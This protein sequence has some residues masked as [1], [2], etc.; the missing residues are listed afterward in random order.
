VAQV[1][2]EVPAVAALAEIVAACPEDPS[3]C[4]SI[5]AAIGV[6]PDD[7]FAL[8]YRDG[9]ITAPT[10]TPSE[11]LALRGLPLVTRALDPK[12]PTDRQPG[13]TVSAF[14]PTVAVI[15]VAAPAGDKPA[16]VAVY[17]GRLGSGF[18]SNAKKQSQYDVTV[19]VGGTVVATTLNDRDVAP[20]AADGHVRSIAA[21]SAPAGRVVSV[22]ALG[23][24]PTVAYSV[25]TA[26]DDVLPLAVLAVSQPAQVALQAE[27]RAFTEVFVTAVVV[28]LLVALIAWQLGRRLVRPVRQLTVVA[29]Q[30]R[31]GDLSARAGLDGVDEVGRL[32]RAMDAMTASLEQSTTDLRTA[33]QEQ[34]AISARLGAVLDSMTEALVVV[35][36]D[37]SIGQANPAAVEL[38]GVPADDLLG[39]AATEVLVVSDGSGPVGLGPG[40]HGEGVLTRDDGRAV[41]VAYS[42]AALTGPGPRG[43]VV[44]L[45]DTTRDREVERMKTEFLSN[46]SHELR[47]PLTP[48]RGYAEILVSKPG[49]DASKV[50]AFATTIRDESVKMNRVVD[51]LVDVAAIEAGRVHIVPRPVAVKDLLDGRIAEWKER[52]PERAKDLKRRVAAG[53]PPVLVDPEWVGKGSEFSLDLPVSDQPVPRRA[54]RAARRP[55]PARDRAR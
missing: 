32:A 52:A 39:R 44:L 10:L 42:S 37:G 5:F 6:L 18:A 41:P 22:P 30:V 8:V 13:G 27:R 24:R 50:T 4:L 29:A 21:R 38:L 49:L 12:I 1:Q 9:R 26:P 20:V 45:R 2:D 33:A 7:F 46:V 3:R 48:I 17:G 47:T 51:L 43:A 16:F 11:K 19:L 34:Q 55:A 36:A 31:R 54:S 53:L 35:E 14:G 28:L 15:G 23:D 40:A 25:I